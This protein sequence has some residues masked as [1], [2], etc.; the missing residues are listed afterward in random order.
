[1]TGFPNKCILLHNDV[2]SDNIMVFLFLLFSHHVQWLNLP[3]FGRCNVG[4]HALFD[5]QRFSL[6]IISLSWTA[7]WPVSYWLM[8]FQQSLYI[9]N[10]HQINQGCLGTKAQLTESNI[11]LQKFCALHVIF[12][13][14]GQS[15]CMLFCCKWPKSLE[16]LNATIFRSDV[17]GQVMPL[18]G[19]DWSHS[20]VARLFSAIKV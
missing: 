15:I 2:W 14:S 8:N 9:L 12:L 13:C 11:V 6:F 5:Y 20:G 7:L 18:V 3:S 1:M 19:R 17:L 4:F 16:V 10:C